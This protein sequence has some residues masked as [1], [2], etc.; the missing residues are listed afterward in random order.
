MPDK[1][2]D[3]PT[4]TCGP[5]QSPPQS[6][7]YKSEFKSPLDG[8]IPTL[9]GWRAVAIVGVITAHG[10][11]AL[12]ASAGPW[13]S[14]RL[15][16]LTQKG[17]LGV[18]VFFGISGLLITSRLL[19]EWNRKGAFSLSRFYLRRVF[20]IL[21]PA[22]LYLLLLAIL[23]NL[24]YLDIVPTELICSALFF[25][26]YGL[27]FLPGHVWFSDHF[28]SLSIEEHFYMLWPLL[29]ACL[30]KTIRSV[31]WVVGICMAI[32]IWREVNFN[33]WV[34]A[35]L[36]SVEPSW[37]SDLRFD[38]LLWGAGA[39]LASYNPR[40]QRWLKWFNSYVCVGAAALLLLTAALDVPGHLV[41]KPVLIVTIILGTCTNPGSTWGRL[42]EAPAARWIG[43]LSYSIYLYQQ[44][45]LVP[46]EHLALFRISGVGSL[47]LAI[48]ALLLMAMMSFHGVEVP[49]IAVGQRIVRRLDERHLARLRQT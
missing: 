11:G 41:I 22:M 43:K 12:F 24:N 33:L 7:L 44:L 49:M 36:H 26:N 10:G 21:P 39:A 19:A 4:D 45:F 25:R 18:D 30:G 34:P 47:V 38:A 13:P 23:G 8:R 28:W 31:F 3:A 1:S 9:D 5:S 46:P 15:L 37:R 17:A 16:N 48:A 20:R 40:T 6:R 2:V 42:L 14:S 35:V 27:A 32:A 29:F